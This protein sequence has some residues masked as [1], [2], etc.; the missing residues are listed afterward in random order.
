VF[1]EG[2]REYKNTI[3][4]VQY[5]IE[6][7]TLQDQMAV[8]AMSEHKHPLPPSPA[9]IYPLLLENVRDYAIFT[10]DTDR[11]ISSWNVGAERIT[12]YK[13]AEVLGQNAALI[14]TPEDR[15]SGVPEREVAQAKREGRADDERWHLKKDGSRFWASG[16][17]TA[18]YDEA[19]ELRAFVKILRDFTERKRHEEEIEA[20]NIRLH[21][22]MTE[23]HHRIKNNLQV[24]AALV[25]MKTQEGSA[26][27][28]VSEVQRI[29]QHLRT[30]AAIHE[31]LTEEIKA[32]VKVSGIPLSALLDQLLPLLQ[33]TTGTREVRFNIAEIRLPS[34]QGT[35]IAIILNELISNA[36]KHGK[37]AIDL[38]ITAE[39]GAVSLEVCDDGPGFPEG[40]EA[41]EAAHTGLELVETLSQFD[42]G[43]TVAYE[44]LAEGGGRVR[45]DFP[46]PPL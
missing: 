7:L 3:E 32:N 35:A 44:N 41:R 36:V 26:T 33:Q 8:E 10:L 20:L 21:L 9:E 45:V 19:G 22:T 31:L 2:K 11:T 38:T 30:M 37:G 5:T 14:F 43:G 46:L 17:L 18:L 1:C 6:V 27:I 39:G 15:A 29:G 16:I 42:L 40:F 28:P 23:A 25:D 12:G 24:V 34:K 4:E 13:E